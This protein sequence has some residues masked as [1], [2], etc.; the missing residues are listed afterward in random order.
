MWPLNSIDFAT[1]FVNQFNSFSLSG[2]LTVNVLNCSSSINKFNR[3]SPVLVAAPA[4]PAYPALRPWL[5]SSRL[6]RH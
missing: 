4:S 2:H 5:R 1:G 6:R 3:I